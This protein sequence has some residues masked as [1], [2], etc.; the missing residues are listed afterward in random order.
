MKNAMFLLCF[1]ALS[2]SPGIAQ[3]FEQWGL[4]EGAA[5]RLGKGRISQI[6]YSPDGTRLAVASTIGIWLYDTA[7]HQEV[8]L[9]AGQTYVDSVAFS[10]DGSTIACGSWPASIR[11]WD[12]ETGDHLRKLK[13]HLSLVFSVAFS[14][15]GRTMASGS[16]DG[17]SVAFSPD[18][19][20]MVHVELARFHPSVGR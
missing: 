2:L 13:G 5:A 18:G 16:E 4:P 14:P 12:A 7:T 9:L 1:F 11:L 17:D 15:D 10:P 8:A 20:T 3:E 6:K 19:S